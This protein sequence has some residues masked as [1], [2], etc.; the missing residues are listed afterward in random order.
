MAEPPKK[1]LRRN[2]PGVREEDWSQWPLVPLDQLESTF[3]IQEYLQEQI[4][5][6]PSNL[7]ALVDLPPGQDKNLWRYEHL[8][9][10][11]QELNTFLVAL[12]PE[13]T[14]ESCPEMKASE[15]IYLCASHANPQQCCAMDYGVHT[16]DNAWA[17]LNNH[18]SFP[19][20]VTIPASSIKHFSNVTR[21]IYRIFAHAWYN[22]RETFTEYECDC[23]LYARFLYLIKYFD[24]S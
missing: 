2:R 20:R 1:S 6:D 24:V 4:R 21:R 11:C 10:I 7:T 18:K 5:N 23:H 22:H 19:S 15:W 14:P 8:R 13:C 9:Q 3:L 17:L 12:E 16:L